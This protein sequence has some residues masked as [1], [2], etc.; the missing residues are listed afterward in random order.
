MAPPT[1]AFLLLAACVLSCAAL[2]PAN[3]SDSPCALESLAGCL[4]R[5]CHPCV[6]DNDVTACLD[7]VQVE[8]IEATDGRG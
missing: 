8:A 2:P 1:T 3:L 7:D 4:Q 5:S 6:L